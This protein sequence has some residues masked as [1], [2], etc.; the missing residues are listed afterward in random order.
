VTRMS[1]FVARCKSK[2]SILGVDALFSGVGGR[3]KGEKRRKTVSLSTASLYKC[4]NGRKKQRNDG[5]LT[6]R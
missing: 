3:E 5:G 2:S 6:I 4:Q 1:E